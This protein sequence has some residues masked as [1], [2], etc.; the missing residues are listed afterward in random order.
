MEIIAFGLGI[1]IGMYVSSQ[2]E[3]HVDKNIKK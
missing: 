2:I 1:V 3:K